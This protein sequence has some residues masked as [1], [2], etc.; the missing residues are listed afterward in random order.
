[1]DA[2]R[3][4]GWTCAAIARTLG[5][6]G[7]AA[8]AWHAR[9]LAP[10]AERRADLMRLALDKAAPPPERTKAQAQRDFHARDDKA[11][12]WKQALA[13]LLASGRTGVALARSLGVH[14]ECVYA[15]R[16][17]R[18]APSAANRAALMAQNAARATSAGSQNILRG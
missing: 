4:D 8:R 17:G 1:M 18:Y 3:R 2:L 6:S 9:T 7:S 5:V 12:A 16:S 11:D 15:W 10:N 14:K 13:E